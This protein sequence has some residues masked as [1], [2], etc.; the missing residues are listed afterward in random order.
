MRMPWE[1]DINWGNIATTF[2]KENDMEWIPVSKRLPNE[3]RKIYLVSTDSGYMYSCRWTNANP[4]WTDLTTDWHWNF[5]DIPQN[6]EVV[7]WMEL[8][9][10]K[11]ERRADEN[12]KNQ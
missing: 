5:A 1:D 6:S 12:I 9:P 2:G 3:E 10:Y 8:E 4:F 11:G 7:A